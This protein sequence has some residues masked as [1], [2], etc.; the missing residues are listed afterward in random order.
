MLRTLLLIGILAVAHAAPASAQ[1]APDAPPCDG[2]VAV[3][4]LTEITPTG[5]MKAYLAAVDAHREWYR[6]HGYTGNELYVTKVAVTDPKTHVMT[7]S[8]NQVLAFHVRPPLMPGTTGHD[9]S[10]DA[11][12]Q[13]YRDNSVIKTSYIV[14]IPKKR[15]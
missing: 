3:I 10:W 5:T 6:S 12:H 13:Q 1:T 8:E 15:D 9:A 4:R 7:Y 14:C 2:D 11:F